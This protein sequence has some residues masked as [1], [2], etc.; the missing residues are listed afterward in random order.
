M[1]PFLNS[2]KYANRENKL[3]LLLR[4]PLLL[5]LHYLKFWD[6]PIPL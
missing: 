5:L 2:K 3:K 1:R 4:C 6:V